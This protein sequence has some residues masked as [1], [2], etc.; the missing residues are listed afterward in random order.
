MAYSLSIGFVAFL[1]ALA[2]GRPLIELLRLRRLG[3]AIS[4]D[5]PSSHATKAGTPTMG[6]LLILAVLLCLT[7]AANLF[8]DPAVL[9]PLGVALAAGLMGLADDALTLEGRER[10]EAHVRSIMIAKIG[11]LIAIGLVASLILYH[12]L[13]IRG[14]TIPHFGD[15]EIGPWFIPLAVAVVVATSSAVA[16]SDGL[17]GL[18]AGTTALAFA[19]YG[20]VAVLQDQGFV[21]TFCFTIVGATLGFL[22]YNAHPARVFMGDT[23]AQALGA[24]LAVVALMT[25][26]WLLLPLIGVVFV[27]EALSVVIQVAYFRLTGGRRV[28]RMSPLHHH[29][30]LLGWPEPQVVQRFWLAGAMAAMLGIALVLT[31]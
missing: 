25:G 24:G 30:E 5:G 10:L 9:L 4:A 1:L 20:I 13:D 22:W 28:F 29:F 6:G 14:L 2:A 7:L 17:D 19:T 18:T 16:I 15:S 23:G 8:D 3:K 26:W 31:D 21:A 11:G 27:A 12:T